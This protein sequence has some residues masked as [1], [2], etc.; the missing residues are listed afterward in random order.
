[1][2]LRNTGRKRVLVWARAENPGASGVTD[3]VRT[4][5]A[6]AP[7]KAI[8]LRLRLMRRHSVPCFALRLA[9]LPLTLLLAATA[10]SFLGGAGSNWI[11][12]RWSG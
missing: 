4:A 3:N 10:L 7:G 12:G 11:T 9:L 5:V 2:K 6:L 1:M 8:T